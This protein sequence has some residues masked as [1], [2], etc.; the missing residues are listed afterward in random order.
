MLTNTIT[1]SFP[2][3]VRIDINNRCPLDPNAKD[4]LEPGDLN[5]MFENITDINGPFKEHV[6]LVYS[7]PSGIDT[8]RIQ[9][10]IDDPIKNGPWIIEFE[11]F[12]TDEEAD[13]LVELGEEL[14]YE[15]ST[16]VGEILADGSYGAKTSKSRTST[17][18]WCVDKCYEDP[19]AKSVYNRI[20]KVT[21][22]PEVNQENLQLLHYDVGQY[23]NSHHDYIPSQRQRQCGPRILTF[24]LY[25]NNVEEGG[26]T[27][28]NDLK[29]SDGGMVVKP[30]KGKALLW[31]SVINEDPEQMEYRTHHQAMPVIK[32]V[33]VAAN[34]WIHLRDFKTPNEISCT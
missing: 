29:V 8:S 23:Y 28:F 16:D 32:G 6:P 10:A 34:A 17:N 5:K 3:N 4:A 21:G 13:R 9:Y 33:K 2:Q 26:E 15:R 12:S 27:K 22:T 1:H 18:A 11:K 20:S 25:L 30:K 19:L 14:G 7:H 24:F 31:P